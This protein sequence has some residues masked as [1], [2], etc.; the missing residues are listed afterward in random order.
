MIEIYEK[1]GKWCFRDDAGK[2]HKFTTKE[3]AMYLGLGEAPSDVKKGCSDCDC[4]PC[5][6][7]EELSE[8]D[9]ADLLKELEDE[10]EGDE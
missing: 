6:C 7:E 1:R 2:L 10:L 8:S 4:D 5:Q 9:Y 3:E